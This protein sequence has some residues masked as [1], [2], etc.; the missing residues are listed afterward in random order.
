MPRGGPRPGAGRK[1]GS[2][3]KATQATQAAVAASGITP[4]DY[5]LEVMRDKKRSVPER[6]DAAHKAAPYVHPRLA[7]IEHSGGLNLITHEAALD[8]LDGEGE[9]DPSPASS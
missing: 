6:V 1:R 8:E 7:A 3:N 2:P 5:L 9:G 4:L